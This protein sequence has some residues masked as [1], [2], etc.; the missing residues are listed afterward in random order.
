MGTFKN[1][2]FS[3]PSF[4]LPLIGG[5]S[6]GYKTR[7]IQWLCLLNRMLEWHVVLSHQWLNLQACLLQALETAQ[8]VLKGFDHKGTSEMQFMEVPLL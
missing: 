5:V 1:L 7:F 8:D 3:T 4:V 6:G 2:V